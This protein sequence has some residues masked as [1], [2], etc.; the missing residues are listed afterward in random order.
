MNESNIYDLNKVI[1]IKINN[2]KIKIN[3]ENILKYNN[4]EINFFKNKHNLIRYFRKYSEMTIPQEVLYSKLL[5]KYKIKSCLQISSIIP[6]NFDRLDKLSSIS[7]FKMI[8]DENLFFEINKNYDAII[9]NPL[10]Y[11]IGS[12]KYDFYVDALIYSLNN[13]IMKMKN[14]KLLVIQLEPNMLLPYTF[15][16]LLNFAKHADKVNTMNLN[17]NN[18]YLYFK[19]I[20]N[21]TID[22]Q[23]GNNLIKSHMNTIDDMSDEDILNE[24]ANCQSN[25]DS[26]ASSYYC[27]INKTKTINENKIKVMMYP[28]V[29]ECNNICNKIIKQYLKMLNNKQNFVNQ[30]FVQKINSEILSKIQYEKKYKIKL[31]NTF[32]KVIAKNYRKMTYNFF[33]PKELF[34]ITLINKKQNFII[35]KR[36]KDYSYL[37]YV[38]KKLFYYEED[39]DVFINKYGPKKIGFF[40]SQLKQNRGSLKFT[41][42]ER[43]KKNFKYVDKI[44][45]AYLKM[46]EVLAHFKLLQNKP[47]INSFH[48][49]ELPGGFIMA[50]NTFIKMMN[51]DIVHNWFGNSYNPTGRTK[52]EMAKTS[53]GF[54]DAYGLLKRNPDRWNFGEDNTGD[55]TKSK[56]ILFIRDKFKDVHFDLITG[57]GGVGNDNLTND[58]MAY[59]MQK[60][61]FGQMVMTMNIAKKGSNCCIKCFTNNMKDN[62][63]MHKSF[64]LY[65]SIIK[66]YANTFRKIF[67]VKPSL[68]SDDSGEY[69]IVGIDFIGIDDEN[70]K[71]LLNIMDNFEVNIT[72]TNLDDDFIN[73]CMKFYEQ[74][75]SL[76]ADNMI[77][78]NI[79]ALCNDNNVYEILKEYLDFTQCKLYFNDKIYNDKVAEFNEKWLYENN[80]H[81]PKDLIID[82]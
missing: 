4:D 14:V 52:E 55:L 77:E 45:D 44:N 50:T 48:F 17:D 19:S 66:T 29:I 2:D 76:N 13:A 57:D 18:L 49:A 80:Y 65:L 24:I 60:L 21:F 63:M 75:S 46:F 36:N 33:S 42:M 59:I 71:E 79:L 25:N 32:K 10:K 64:G 56:N 7:D 15:Y 61:D 22:N 12:V 31:S 16:S 1:D 27:E 43:Y 69:Y 62:L 74:L 37:N 3:L 54:D 51:R 8:T 68:S 47:Q 67:L 11:I 26:I 53:I 35:E 81:L 6:K 28:I 82:I 70:R 78:Q 20:D 40:K 9:F 73:Q 58:E 38:H 30:S 39:R 41:I 5:K 23:I 72:F 34:K